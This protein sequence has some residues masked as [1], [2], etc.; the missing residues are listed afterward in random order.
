MSVN[1]SGEGGITPLKTIKTEK[2]DSL[3]SGLMSVSGLISL[4][5]AIFTNEFSTGAHSKDSFVRKSPTAEPAKGEMRDSYQLFSASLALLLT[6][7]LFTLSL[8]SLF[9]L[10]LQPLTQT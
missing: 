9:T 3:V 4:N 7:Q 10:H 8:S 5:I 6:L 2:L 1:W